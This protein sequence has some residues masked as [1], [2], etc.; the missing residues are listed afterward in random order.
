VV[1]AGR[2]ARLCDAVRTASVLGAAAAG[3]VAVAPVHV[4]AEAVPAEGAR[5]GRLGG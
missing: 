3:A 4:P 5:G 1:V 2:P